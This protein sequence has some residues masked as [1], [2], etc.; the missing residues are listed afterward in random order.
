M[1]GTFLDIAYQRSIPNLSA[2]A[3]KWFPDRRKLRMVIYACFFLNHH[4]KCF[5]LVPDMSLC[6]LYVLSVGMRHWYLF[7]SAVS[8]GLGL[9][10]AIVSPDLHA[11]SNILRTW[12][13]S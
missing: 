6:Q 13:F 8:L 5:N 4:G 3:S 11:V 12:F 9:T 1:S 2:W 7:S 10:V